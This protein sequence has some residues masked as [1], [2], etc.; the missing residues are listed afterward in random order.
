MSIVYLRLSEIP[1]TTVNYVFEGARGS[2]SALS[3]ADAKKAA[4]NFVTGK[5]NELPPAVK[6]TAPIAVTPTVLT[7]YPRDQNDRR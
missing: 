7:K 4:Q 3:V 6:I 2:M 1:S 5:I